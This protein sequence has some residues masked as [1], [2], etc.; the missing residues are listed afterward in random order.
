VR[1]K[2]AVYCYRR[3]HLQ[4]IALAIAAIC[5]SNDLEAEGGNTGAA[6]YARS[7]EKAPT[8]RAVTPFV[9]RQQI[10]LSSG[11]LRKTLPI[12]DEVLDDLGHEGERDLG[13]GEPG[14]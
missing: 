9:A 13:G 11:S 4:S 14:N 6:L 7:R 2:L 12:A 3:S 5:D 8:P 1:A 10:T